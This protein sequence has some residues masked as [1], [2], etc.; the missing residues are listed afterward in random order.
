MSLAETYGARSPRNIVTASTPGPLQRVI[1][2]RR[3][4][5]PRFRVILPGIFPIQ[6][7][8]DHRVL[9]LVQ[10]GLAR[11][12]MLPTRCCAASAGRHPRVHKANQ[13][14]KRM[15]AENHAHRA[16][17]P[18][19]IDGWCKACCQM[20]RH[21]SDRCRRGR[22][23]DRASSQHA[24]VGRHP[25]DAQIMRDRQRFFR[26][27]ALR[28]PHA[29]A[30]A[31][32]KLAR[33]DRVRAAIARAHPR[34]AETGSAEAAGRETKPRPHWY[35]NQ[36]KNGV[37]KRRRRKLNRSFLRGLRMRRQ[38][39]RQ[40]FPLRAKTKFLIVSR[41]IRALA[42]SSATFR[43]RPERIRR[44]RQSAKAPAGRCSPAG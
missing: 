27:A 40:K 3:N 14:R 36:R 24:F 19:R 22:T 30:A 42:I 2:R 28:G 41:I 1:K 35:R 25:L 10:H 6:N 15:I 18:S 43:S 13:V 4:S 44:T 12:L 39:R 11:S 37:I 34:D 9:P 38:Y 21:I 20:S 32:Q 33:A 26:D 5:L 17:Q 31:S 16:C 23:R 7:D 8:R 29:L